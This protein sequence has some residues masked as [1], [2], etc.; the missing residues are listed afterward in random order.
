MAAVIPFVI[1]LAAA[2]AVG[3]FGVAA[4]VLVAGVLAMFWIHY[5]YVP[6]IVKMTAR[7]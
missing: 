3:S 7:G 6:L 2:R 1:A 4:I 5:K